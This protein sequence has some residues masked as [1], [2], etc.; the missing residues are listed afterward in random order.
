[1][2]GKRVIGAVIL[3]FGLTAAGCSTPARVSGGPGSTGAGE[4]GQAWLGY[5][6]HRERL[7][8]LDELLD[9]RYRAASDDPFVRQFHPDGMYAD[10]AGL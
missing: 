8:R 1:M 10:W 7:Y 9:P 6:K 5:L 2:T 3:S 4:N